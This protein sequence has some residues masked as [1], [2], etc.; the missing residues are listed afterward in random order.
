MPQTNQ[1]IRRWYLERVATIPELNREWTTQGLSS[2]E[3]AEKAWH[4]RHEARSQARSMMSNPVE[5]ELLRARDMARYGNPDGPTFEWL[6]EQL[7][8]AGLEGDA[9]YEAII[10][11]SYRTDIEL[12]RRLGC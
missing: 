12:N 1:E 4:I 8:D 11:R 5:V 10:E 2:R 7:E 6:A 9:V 3:R